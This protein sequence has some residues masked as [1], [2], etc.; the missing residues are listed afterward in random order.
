MCIFFSNDI[1][2]SLNCVTAEHSYSFNVEAKASHHQKV[3]PVRMHKCD[4]CG[5]KTKSDIHFAAHYLKQ[6]EVTKICKRN[7]TK[8]PSVPQKNDDNGPTYKCEQ[9][10]YETKNKHMFLYHFL[11][12]KYPS[13][14]QMMKCINC[15]YTSRYKTNLVYH[16]LKHGTVTSASN[17]SFSQVRMY[18]CDSC[19]YQS[20]YKNNLADHQSKHKSGSGTDLYMCDSH[21]KTTTNLTDHQIAHESPQG[22]TYKCDHQLIRTKTQKFRC[23]DCDFETKYRKNIIAHVF[24]H[25]NASQIKEYNNDE[26]DFE[27]DKNNATSNVFRAA[28]KQK[29]K[30]ILD[31]TK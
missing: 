6:T 3:W 21:C 24:R 8:V 20:R 31:I 27:S 22:E 1:H 11:T 4:E 25:K 9:C 26:N 2:P 23:N 7:N 16:I 15:S 13:N 18:K 30:A 28:I 19:N 29:I 14:V 17:S 10:I 5:Y 12:H